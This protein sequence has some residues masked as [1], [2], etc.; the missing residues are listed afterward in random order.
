[1]GEN[2]VASALVHEV[3]ELIVVEDQKISGF[4]IFAFRGVGRKRPLQPR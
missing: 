3:V 2:S 1:M 4:S